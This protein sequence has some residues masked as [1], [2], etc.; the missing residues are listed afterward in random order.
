MWIRR[1]ELEIE[2]IDARRERK[3]TSYVRPLYLAV[4][5]A[6]ACTVL[7]AYGYRGG[8][9]RGFVM[10]S[11]PMPLFGTKALFI[12]VVTFLILYTLMYRSQR[13]GSTLFSGEDTLFCAECQE[14]SHPN[15][16]RRCSCG[17]RQEPF[18]YYTWEEDLEVEEM[19]TR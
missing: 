14:P 19:A 9:T 18:S 2:E 5:I 8:I 16:E 10:Y 11:D 12:G 1:S 4:P 15:P 13:R 6:L 17:E 3:R 7:Y